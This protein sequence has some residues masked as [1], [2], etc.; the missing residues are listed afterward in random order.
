MKCIFNTFQDHQLVY[1]DSIIR[2]KSSSEE[3]KEKSFPKETAIVKD[4]MDLINEIINFNQSHEELSES[5]RKMSN[6]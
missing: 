3:Q 4:R 6:L 2:G 1:I 5:E